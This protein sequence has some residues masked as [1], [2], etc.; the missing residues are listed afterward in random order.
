ML[1]VVLNTAR[2]EQKCNEMWAAIVQEV[3]TISVEVPILSQRIRRP[4]HRLDNDSQTHQDTSCEDLYRRIYFS[5]VDAA[6]TCL[7]SRF[8][9]A[10]FNLARNMKA[11]N[12]YSCNKL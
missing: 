1:S 11:S 10:A 8:Q 2:D 5:A 9:S 3:S 12:C 7:K 6:M 4:A